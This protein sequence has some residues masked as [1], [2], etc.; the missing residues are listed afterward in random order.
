MSVAK[1]RFWSS[2]E[3]LNTHTWRQQKAIASAGSTPTLSKLPTPREAAPALNQ[4]PPVN[5][6]FFCRTEWY[7]RRKTPPAVFRARVQLCVIMPTGTRTT[8]R[9]TAMWPRGSPG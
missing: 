2:S 6:L 9:C 5:H 4:R 3:L 8:P 7:R 1:V